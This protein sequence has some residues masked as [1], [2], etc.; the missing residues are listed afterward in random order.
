[1]N[2]YD[3]ENPPLIACENCGRTNLLTDYEISFDSDGEQQFDCPKCGY[4]PKETYEW[5]EN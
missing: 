3:K 1:V 4:T 2:Y 5:K